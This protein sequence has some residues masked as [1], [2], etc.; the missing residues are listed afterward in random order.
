M[1][2]GNKQ[3]LD[4][5][6]NYVSLT[7]IQDEN[8]DGLRVLQIGHQ[9]SSGDERQ[10]GD[11]LIKLTIAPSILTEKSAVIKIA[12]GYL[13]ELRGELES[14]I[15]NREELSSFR[16]YSPTPSSWLLSKDDEKQ[17]NSSKDISNDVNTVFT[18]DFR[19]LY[20]PNSTVVKFHHEY[21]NIPIYGSFASVEIDENHKPLGL[22]ATLPINSVDTS[23][24][25]TKEKQAILDVVRDKTGSPDIDPEWE[26]RCSL[27]WYFDKKNK[28]W[29]LVYIV[30]RVIDGNCDKGNFPDIVDY[31]IDAYSSTYITKIYRTQ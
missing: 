4:M 1:V 24:I 27:N 6:P 26:K 25:P 28:M 3:H 17:I 7:V 19:E 20:E 23:S 29:K 13:D 22:S 30:E 15:S 14:G 16:H 21:Q 2:M 31:I 11:K 9:S 8:R 5:R 10:S 18:G 12:Q